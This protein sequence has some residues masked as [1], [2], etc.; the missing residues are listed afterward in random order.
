MTFKSTPLTAHDIARATKADLLLC[1]VAEYALNGWALLLSGEL[2]PYHMHRD[3]VPHEKGRITWGSRVI[4]P[5]LLRSTV[6]ALLQEGHPGSRRMKMLARIFIWWPM[7]DHA[8]ESV[9][10]QC[11]VCQ[12]LQNAAPSVPLQPW[13]YPTMCWRRIQVD[14][15]TK[16]KHAFRDGRRFF[17]NGS[18]YGQCLPPPPAKR[19]KGLELCSKKLQF[20][21][22]FFFNL[23]LHLS[24]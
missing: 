20:R 7:L 11:S 9:V 8:I 1:R 4:I 10:R 14:L 16:R 2:K 3:E 18:K 15:A 12:A 17:R 24:S 22:N 21:D 23:K 5:E 19:L 6:L 13:S